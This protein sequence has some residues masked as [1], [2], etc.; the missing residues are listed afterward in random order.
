MDLITHSVSPESF[1]VFGNKLTNR[2]EILTGHTAAG[3]F[4]AQFGVSC[5]V[6]SIVWDLIRPFKKNMLRNVSAIHLL[7]ALSF[8]K[9]YDSFHVLS[10]HAGV[11]E[12]TFSEWVWRIVPALAALKK[13]M[14]KWEN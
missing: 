3:R 1:L 11:S 8:L 13:H 7:W 5:K 12:K 4:K 2:R 10:A 9:T 14:I 6:C